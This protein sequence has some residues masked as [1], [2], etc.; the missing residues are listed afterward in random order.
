MGNL[1]ATWL[2]LMGWHESVGVRVSLVVSVRKTENINV[3]SLL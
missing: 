1:I 3:P 2:C